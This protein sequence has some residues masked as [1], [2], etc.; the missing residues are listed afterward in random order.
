MSLNG[1]TQRVPSSSSSSVISAQQARPII[2][3]LLNKSTQYEQTNTNNQFID[4]DYVGQLM[5]DIRAIE[6]YIGK[7]LCNYRS[8][9][10]SSIQLIRTAVTADKERVS[11]V[12]HRYHEI[13]ILL[14]LQ[15]LKQ[16]SIV[17]NSRLKR[18][19]VHARITNYNIR[20]RLVC[21][22]H[23]DRIVA[24]TAQIHSASM[25]GNKFGDMTTPSMIPSVHH[26]HL[27]STR[28]TE[29]LSPWD[30]SEFKC[31]LLKSLQSKMIKKLVIELMKCSSM[32]VSTTQRF[33]NS[34]HWMRA[35][36]M[37]QLCF[38]SILLEALHAT[39]LSFIYSMRLKNFYRTKYLQPYLSSL[40]Y[41]AQLKYLRREW[42]CL[43][44][45]RV[46][47]TLLK[48]GIRLLTLYRLQKCLHR[49]LMSWSR[50]REEQ[51]L[52]SM[53]FTAWIL[54]YLRKNRLRRGLMRM[55]NSSS[56]S[57]LNV[58]EEYDEV[59][60]DDA[61]ISTPKKHR[62]NA[63]RLLRVALDALIDQPGASN[64]VL[65]R[66]YS[67]DICRMWSKGVVDGMVASDDKDDS[68]NSAVDVCEDSGSIVDSSDSMIDGALDW[69]SPLLIPS[70]RKQMMSSL[71]QN[72]RRSNINNSR[73]KKYNDRL[74]SGPHPSSY[75]DRSMDAMTHPLHDTSSSTAYQSFNASPMRDSSIDALNSRLF[76][77]N[78]G[79]SNDHTRRDSDSRMDDDDGGLGMSSFSDHLKRPCQRSISSSC[80]MAR[81]N[82][83]ERVRSNNSKRPLHHMQ[84]CSADSMLYDSAL[85]MSFELTPHP[86][87]ICK[88]SSAKI[89][90]NLQFC[91]FF[92]D[93][94]S[95]EEELR[96]RRR[97]SAET[98]D[99]FRLIKVSN[100]III[101]ISSCIL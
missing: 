74:M 58:A 99:K 12:Q 80:A 17:Y 18:S 57:V 88:E 13:C 16:S 8:L 75:L 47:T 95:D 24:L 21:T 60:L 52:E 89:M 82:S 11:S 71:N 5:N 46:A 100:R 83:S 90:H 96:E 6:E 54:V 70:I 3:T 63:G 65:I 29:R 32:A 25:S 26:H 40:Q 77:R 86:T 31:Q 85:S 59:D 39:Y 94:D 78:G 20:Q 62:R 55:H 22:E 101:T 51:R 34:C 50:R 92:Q 28:S 97:L 44:A 2:T 15:L 41:R 27:R 38:S 49:I 4:R 35:R 33:M 19:Y 42:M 93:D 36:H 37:L 14:K 66:N 87:T 1:S 53:A 73:S 64:V 76:H 91:G 98:M 68:M 30:G 48:K 23:F 9:I 81:S 56:G 61:V 79:G 43:T 72:I 10:R 67:L 84:M 45:S 69:S 7:E